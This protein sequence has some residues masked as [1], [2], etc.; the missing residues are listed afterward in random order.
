MSK[1]NEYPLKLEIN[2]RLISKIII[3]Q[4]YQLK[5]R[6]INDDLIL[7]LVVKLN[8]GI[9]PIEEQK[10]GFEYFTVEP[11]IHKDKPYKLILL[12]YIHENFLGVINA[13]RIKIR[14]KR[15]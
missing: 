12:L 10:D 9:F 2:G 3:D 7:R 5:H 1:R 15:K 6:E 14:R 11:I 8:G 13:Y 4:H